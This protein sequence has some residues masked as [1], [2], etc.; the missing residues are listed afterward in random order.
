MCPALYVG[1][2]I[3]FLN[4]SRC[5]WDE[6][7]KNSLKSYGI[8]SSCVNGLLGGIF[9]ASNDSFFFFFP[10]NEV[11]SPSRN[12][13]WP[14]LV[15]PSPLLPSH[16]CRLAYALPTRVSLLEL[17]TGIQRSPVGAGDRP[18][19]IVQLG[20]VGRPRLPG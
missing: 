19:V 13:P 9:S 12:W 20:A 1:T 5:L 14:V 11:P 3:F 4:V 2:M 18:E 8:Y 16:S 6:D 17:A 7:N 15:P 10:E